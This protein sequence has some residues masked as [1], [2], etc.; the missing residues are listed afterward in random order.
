MTSRYVVSLPFTLVFVAS[1]PNQVTAYQR[2]TA[3]LAVAE[4]AL[5][6]GDARRAIDLL[7]RM[8]NRDQRNYRAWVLLGR[9]ELAS[10]PTSNLPRIRAINAFRRA[11]ELV[12]DS[13]EPWYWYGRAGLALGGADGEL[14]LKEGTERVLALDPSFEDAWQLW[15]QLYRNG[16]DRDRMRR[17]LVLHG[18]RQDL[19]ARRARLF[20]EDERY[21]SANA[22]LDGLLLS[23]SARPDWLARRAQ[24]AFESGDSVTGA[25]LYDRALMF[26]GRDASVLWEHAIGIAWPD[27]I[28]EWE[29]GIEPDSQGAWLRAFWARRDPDLFRNTNA[30]LAEHFRR[31]R[32]ARRRWPLMYPLLGASLRESSRAGQRQISTSEEVFY[33]RC[34]ARESPTGPTRTED[35][36]RLPLDETLFP[37]FGAPEIRQQVPWPGALNLSRPGGGQVH[38]VANTFNRDLRDVDTTAVAVGY[39]RRTGLDDRGLAYLRMGEPRRVL[40][41]STNVM[42]EFCPIPDLERWQYDGLGTIRFFRPGAVSI[43][44]ASQSSRHSGELV[45]RPMTQ[46]QFVAT[47]TALTTDQTSV[48][49]P[50]AFG[51]WTAQFAGEEGRT[52]LATITT[53]GRAAVALVEPGAAGVP[54]GSSDSG[55]VVVAA[56]P[57]SYDL[58]VNARVADSLG[59]LTRRIRL[60]DLSVGLSDLVLGPTWA[61]VVTRSRALAHA[62][63]SLTFASETTLRLYSEVYGLVPR[64]GRWNYRA[65]YTFWAS[66]NPV[67][68]FSR[69]DMPGA[70]V[71]THERDVLALGQAAAEWLDVGPGRL[72]PGRY[73]LRLEVTDLTS[74]RLLGRS[75]I[76]FAIRAAS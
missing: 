63:R 31:L 69:T 55:V 50:L 28:R 42:D 36:A 13:A 62:S 52:D 1:I 40:I 32:V 6:A 4:S 19:D 10:G 33:Q 25:A 71:I 60:R 17:I 35:R 34:E 76:A 18:T 68:D 45:M 44:G 56:E 8:T 59:R 5:T 57:G 2:N 66:Q 64:D 70:V 65:A 14:I 38:I 22:L 51:A 75:Q 58:L 23:D 53:L 9:A 11:S 24:S 49:A 54:R 21:D 72:A 61:G 37:L 15:L 73:V 41:G 39:N 46:E 3:P 29:A 12:P 43:M 26:A 30:R 20:V 16:T 48:S 47:A 74:G 67:R 27:E 7:R